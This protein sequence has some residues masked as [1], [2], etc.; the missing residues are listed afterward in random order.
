VAALTTLRVATGIEHADAHPASTTRLVETV[1]ESFA[2]APTLNGM[3][4]MSGDGTWVVDLIQLTGTSDGRD[5]AWLRVT[6]HGIYVGE[7]RGWD[8]VASL[9][10][11]ISDLR[12]T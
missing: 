5:G 3:R 10:V 6:H 8:G 7:A 11:D 2:R 4:W 1:N 9:G 12:E